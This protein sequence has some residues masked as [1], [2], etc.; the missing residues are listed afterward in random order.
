MNA[1]DQL[2]DLVPADAI[3]DIEF[4]KY[5][6]PYSGTEM[7]RCIRAVEGFGPH[8]PLLCLQDRP[9]LAFLDASEALTHGLNGFP[10]IPVAGIR[11]ARV[12]P[13]ARELWD[14][15]GLDGPT[16]DR[17]HGRCGAGLS[18]GGAGGLLDVCRSGLH[19]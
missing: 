12:K 13:R 16:V 6:D 2:S 17:S 18:V 9:M 11:N 5:D 19:R 8:S 14:R 15:A 3:E 7:L 4:I 10:W 1:P